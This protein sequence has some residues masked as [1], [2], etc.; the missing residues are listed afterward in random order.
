MLI[1]SF[2][3]HSHG[4]HTH[5]GPSTNTTEVTNISNYEGLS[6]S[7]RD[8]IDAAVAAAMAAGSCQFDYS[9]AMQGCGSM[10]NYDGEYGVNFQIG[11]RVDGL[12]LNGGIAC[13]LDDSDIDQCGFGGAVNWHF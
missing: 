1:L 10:W 9:S 4:G 3:I 6:S 5:D 8:S 2:N 11:Q 13:G 12:L 7:D